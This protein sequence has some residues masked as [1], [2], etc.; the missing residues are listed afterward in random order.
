M[1]CAA[2]LTETTT[3]FTACNGDPTCLC[4]TSAVNSFFSTE[5][6]M[7]NDLINT[8][9]KSPSPLAGSNVLVGGAFF[10]LFLFPYPFPCF[11]STALF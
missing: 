5:T 7:F 10:F 11:C 6:C 8:N 1:Q 9:E 2:N 4:G 3:L